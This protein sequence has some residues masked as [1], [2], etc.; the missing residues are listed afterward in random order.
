MKKQE[1]L[2]RPGLLRKLFFVLFILFAGFQDAFAQTTNAPV[3]TYDPTVY[4]AEDFVNCGTGLKNS[5]G[6]WIVL[7]IY[8]NI[9][10]L[11]SDYYCVKLGN[12]S[13]LVDKTGKTILP[14][15]YARININFGTSHILFQVRDIHGKSGVVDST[16]RVIV[17]L[18]YSVI[19]FYNDGTIG[20]L[21]GTKRWTI[22][23]YDGQSKALP[24]KVADTPHNV[25]DSMYVVEKTP[26]CLQWLWLPSRYGLMDINGK[27][28]FPRRYRQIDYSHSVYNLVRLEKKNKIV[29]CTLDGKVVFEGE[30]DLNKL[31]NTQRAVSVFGQ[32]HLNH[33][34]L[35]I[36]S[37]GYIPLKI[38]GKWGIM[39][40]DG[41]TVLPF[42]YQ[43]LFNSF[44]NNSYQLGQDEYY[45]RTDSTAGIFNAAEKKWIIPPRY[46]SLEVISSY[47]NEKDSSDVLLFIAERGNYYSVISSAGQEILPAIYTDYKQFDEATWFFF[48]GDSS[49]V[50]SLPLL[51]FSLNFRNN[52][53]Y[54][55]RND[56]HIVKRVNADNLFAQK[57]FADGTRIFYNPSLVNDS[58]QRHLYTPFD[59]AMQINPVTYDSL[60]HA[61]A[62]VIQPFYPVIRQGDKNVICSFSGCNLYVF[63]NVFLVNSGT[64]ADLLYFPGGVI[65]P[66]FSIAVREAQDAHHQY[67]SYTKTYVT[68]RYGYRNPRIGIIRDDGKELVRPGSIT[69]VYPIGETDS[70]ER[71]KI[72]AW[73]FS[74]QGIIDGN[75]TV[76]ADTVWNNLNAVRGYYAITH[77]YYWP[78]I[79]TA[80]ENLADLRTGKEIFPKKKEPGSISQ[81]G[82]NNFIADNAE[83]VMVYN[84]GEKRYVNGRGYMKIMRLGVN[85]KYFAVKTCEGHIGIMDDEGKLLSDTCWTA[86]TSGN[87]AV[88]KDPGLIFFAFYNDTAQVVF[89]AETGELLHP[90]S[91]AHRLLKCAERNIIHTQ[92]QVS[93]IKNKSCPAVQTLTGKALDSIPLWAQKVLFDSIFFPVRYS[94]DTLSWKKGKKCAYCREDQYFIYDWSKD[95]EQ[96]SFFWT[97]FFVNDSCI[98]S[99]RSPDN[100]GQMMYEFRPDIAFTTMLFPD[101]PHPMLL[102]SLFDGTGWKEIIISEVLDYL[103]NTPNVDGYCSNPYMFPS[104]LRDRFLIS[105]K[106]LL[107]F[108]SGYTIYMQQV[109]IIIPWEKLKPYLRADVASKIGI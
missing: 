89:N 73:R 44:S 5:T 97:S 67:Y 18:Q 16:G 3:K 47:T 62:I 60:L 105:Q 79:Y 66:D 37:R 32:P 8:T 70:T 56:Q 25:D 1:T 53:Q 109:K 11:T 95:Y 71:F 106:G 54:T 39:G 91:V 41:D 27:M 34:Q 2:Y 13:G 21:T 6:E 92:K 104:L 46:K 86:M 31:D 77:N 75:G 28:L 68:D 72:T 17:P 40:A 15:V 69:K 83:G 107:L 9:E 30:A 103:N 24:F 96:S 7:P 63:N 87:Y 4:I 102:D 45:L 81:L 61:T 55:A 78:H 48:R 42:I 74:K 19:R 90:D 52:Y 98:S 36:N 101:G 22:Y 93:Y 88:K 38:N 76:I 58:T 84:L 82:S 57:D 12:R 20:A 65:S 26:F 43:A 64:G 33:V 100:G 35:Y 59:D 10:S 49:V 99:Y 51:S 29:Y 85:E 23:T 94:P 50:L 14:P 80:R 108:P